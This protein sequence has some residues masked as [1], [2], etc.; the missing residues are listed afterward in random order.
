MKSRTW[1]LALL[2]IVAVGILVFLIR[3]SQGVNSNDYLARLAH[4]RKINEL[5][6][7]FNQ[8]ML[9][10]RVSTLAQFNYKSS[11][12]V[13]QLG[14]ALD[15]LNKGPV[16]LR[17]L[18]PKL[19]QA[20]DRFINTAENKA[21]LA[22]DFVARNLQINGQLTGSMAAVPVD[23]NAL[24]AATNK[25]DTDKVRSL[26]SQLQMQVV[27]FGV[28]PAPTN[29]AEIH[30]LLKQLK[31]IGSSQ[32]PA[33]NAALSKLQSSSEDTIS[34]KDALI[35]R[36]GNFLSLPTASQLRTVEQDYIDWHQQQTAIANRYR[37]L[38]AAYAGFLLLVLAALGLRLLRSFR[39]LDR[40]NETLEAQVEA[41]THELSEALNGLK[42]SQSQLIQSEK[43]A[44]L[45]QMVAGVAHEI[46]TP[47]GYARS[48]AE[49]VRSSL[50]DL[51]KLCAAQ[52]HALRLI[53]TGAAN[54]EEIAQALTSAHALSE[55]LDAD[56]LGED[57]D[58]L[59][60]DT[61][62]GL[63]QIG[64]LVAG[65]KDFSRVDRSRTDLFNINDGLDAALK[66]ARNQ[67]K[68]RIEVVRSYNEVPD[69][70]C[71]PSQLNQVF[72]NLLVNAAQAIEGE[73]R[74]YLHTK[75]ESDA[76]SVRIV[77]TG[78]GMDETL[79]QRIFEPF[80][81]TKPVGKGTGLGLSIVFRI[82]EDHGGRIE[83]HSTPGKGS[84]FAIR[85]PLRQP[86]TN[87]DAA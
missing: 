53:N 1:L 4:L 9:Q 27:V 57:L 80:F 25:A 70:E 65:L 64:E 60:A 33:Y 36:L 6:V 78:S 23:V 32:T 40:A 35:K 68:H 51:R 66:I 37:I 15:G 76:V 55:S 58:S 48:N 14:H 42:A 45:G 26:A 67:L 5:D 43:M 79:R 87:A 30:A 72:L 62:H 7:Q 86:R 61:N 59:L 16:A 85:L 46:N 69:I 11:Q 12:I 54:D 34:A 41:R 83:V 17:G 81:T 56:A 73:G 21:G 19:D 8:S 84:A 22:Y 24:V 44:S 10:A 74:V 18:S 31:Q 63:S 75:A 2:A 77:D 29:K 20:L 13:R 28:T 50:G 38:L 39:E 47:L 82:I 71:S 52:G 49:I 3:M